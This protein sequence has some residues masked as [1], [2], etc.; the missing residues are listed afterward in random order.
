M[1]LIPWQKI[2]WLD[3]HIATGGLQYFAK[4]LLYLDN[5]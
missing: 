5:I 3:C 2:V 4:A 1:K